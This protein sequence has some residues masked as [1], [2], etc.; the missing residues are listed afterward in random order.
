M[1]LEKTRIVHFQLGPQNLSVEL[2]QY[3]ETLVNKLKKGALLWRDEAD[4]YRWV[5]L[6]ELKNP[7]IKI[8]NVIVFV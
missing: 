3:D 6:H 1:Y 2:V 7:M 5:H 8:V 4:A